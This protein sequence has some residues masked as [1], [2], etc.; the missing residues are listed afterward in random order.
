MAMTIRISRARAAP[1]D[2]EVRKVE[3]QLGVK[4]P[5]DYLAFVK[6]SNG[7]TPQTNIFRISAKIESGINQFIPF[8]KIAYESGLIREQVT[9]KYVP[10]AY[11][12]GGNYL[13]IAA[14][15]TEAGM[16]YFLDHEVPGLDA[17]TQL[18][19]S[20]PAFLEL[21][22]PFDTKDIQLKPGQVKK[23]WIDPSLLK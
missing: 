16:V 5:A 14:T 12:E 7:G 15:G 3:A 21:L 2:D 20:L 23:A 10:I 8:D 19:D 17:L 18:A 22:K 13:C 1:S 6:H 11:A 9:N 4:L